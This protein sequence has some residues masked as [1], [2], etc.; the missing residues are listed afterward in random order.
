[1]SPA[2]AQDLAASH[3]PSAAQWESP[4]APCRLP[5]DGGNEL[6]NREGALSFCY[7]GTK[8]FSKVPFPSG[9][10]EIFEGK[11]GG[12]VLGDSF[13]TNK[14]EAPHCPGKSKGEQGG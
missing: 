14:T 8:G 6:R 4:S 9:L 12:R 2:A 13:K 3:C 5:L 10:L 11:R 1:M 7:P